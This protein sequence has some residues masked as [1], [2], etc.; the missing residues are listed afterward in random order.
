MRD[1]LTRFFWAFVFPRWR[2]GLGVFLAGLGAGAASLPFPLLLRRVIDEV[3]PRGDWRGLL[4]YK[5]LLLD[6]VLAESLLSYVPRPSRCAG[7]KPSSIRP[8]TS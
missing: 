8:N 5:L 6:L 4:T 1:P 3:A 7:A 2:L